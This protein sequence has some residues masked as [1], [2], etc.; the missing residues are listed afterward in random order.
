M[1]VVSGIDV[2]EEIDQQFGVAAL[3]AQMDIAD[4][5]RAEA[6]PFALRRFGRGG[7]VPFE[8]GQPRHHRAV[9]QIAFEIVTEHRAGT[10]YACHG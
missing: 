3:G 8:I 1:T 7:F 5:D 2:V 6:A 9:A 10:L 4:P